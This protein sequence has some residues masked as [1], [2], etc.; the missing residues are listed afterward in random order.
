MYEPSIEALKESLAMYHKM[1]HRSVEQLS[2]EQLHYRPS[3][4]TNSVA[5][6]L[7]HLGGNLKSRWTDFLTTDGEKPDRN[8]DS[9]FE[10]WTGDRES[11]MQHFQ[12]GWDIFLSAIDQ[13][14]ESNIDQPIVVRGEEQPM[15]TALVRAVTHISYHVGQITMTSRL[16]LGSDWQ[17]MTIPPGES[18]A[19]NKKTWGSKESRCL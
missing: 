4:E 5:I 16:V 8:R 7:R 11:L 17:W 12:S 13:I 3:A 9:E 15:M 19:H 14:N 18:E 6:I 1:I 2:D 10:D